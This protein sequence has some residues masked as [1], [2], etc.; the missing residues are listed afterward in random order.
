M[1]NTH[2]VIRID[3]HR[4]LM[5]DESVADEGGR[6]PDM[7]ERQGRGPVPKYTGP[8]NKPSKAVRFVFLLVGAAL[9]AALVWHMVARVVA[10]VGGAA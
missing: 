1:A 4:A 6:A 8:R 5:Q 7:R 10:Q 9:A 3:T 2:R